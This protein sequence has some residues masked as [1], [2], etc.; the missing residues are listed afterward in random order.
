MYRAE[1]NTGNTYAAGR[2]VPGRI[3]FI[4]PC[5]SFRTSCFLSERLRA[6]FHGF[7]SLNIHLRYILM[8]LAFA[9]PD[10]ITGIFFIIVERYGMNRTTKKTFLPDGMKSLTVSTALTS[11]LI[12]AVIF[13]TRFGI[14]A[15][16][17]TAGAVLVFPLPANLLLKAFMRLFNSFTPSEEGEL[18]GKLTSLFTKY[19]VEMKRIV[20]VMPPAV[21]RR[22][23]HSA[24]V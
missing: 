10:R 9:T 20:V 15:G 5:T 18:R 21:R 14:E 13:F 22:P 17:W 3:L 6:V 4:R 19:G 2:T 12:S 16:V 11:L 1:R 23:K 24:R 7:A 8:I